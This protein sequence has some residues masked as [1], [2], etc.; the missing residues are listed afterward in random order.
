M[1]GALKKI[2]YIYHVIEQ[3]FPHSDDDLDRVVALIKDDDLDAED[4]R[5]MIEKAY[6]RGFVQGANRTRQAY[7]NEA[8]LIDIY[9]WIDIDLHLNWRNKTSCK[10]V[11]YP[12]EID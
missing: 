7:E 4:L 5:V 11:V 6:R 9:Y 3:D 1:K 8:A 2:K 12:P 10:T